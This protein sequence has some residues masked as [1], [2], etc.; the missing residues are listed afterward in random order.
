MLYEAGQPRSEATRHLLGREIA[1]LYKVSG[2]HA[3]ALKN[4]GA[5]DPTTLPSVPNAY[6]VKSTGPAATLDLVRVVQALPGV[7]TVYPLL[8]KQRFGR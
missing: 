7:T 3:K 8:K 5:L 2:D 1:V 4:A 6:V